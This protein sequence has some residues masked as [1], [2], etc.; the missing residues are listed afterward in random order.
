MWKIL[1]AS[2]RPPFPFVHSLPKW[3][4]TCPLFQMSS[5]CQYLQI[6]SYPRLLWALTIKSNYLFT[7]IT[8]MC[9][10]PNMPQQNSGSSLLPQIGFL[11]GFLSSTPPIAEVR[12]YKSCL[13]FLSL[14]PSKAYIL[15][16][17]TGFVWWYLMTLAASLHFISISPV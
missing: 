2:L 7:I 12:T 13:E 3:V 9:Q 11:Q 16:S 10:V 14:S 15:L 4:Q 5:T 8:M 17:P 1:K 6:H